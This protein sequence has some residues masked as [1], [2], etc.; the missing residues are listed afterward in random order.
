M[1]DVRGEARNCGR[2]RRPAPGALVFAL[3][4]ACLGYAFNR[5]EAWVNRTESA[6][7][8]AIATVFWVG[9]LASAE[10]RYISNVQNAW[11]RDWQQHFGGVDHPEDRCGY[12][13]CAFNPRENSFYVAL[14]FD[15]MTEEGRKKAGTSFIPW[16]VPRTKRSVL[17][18]RWIAIHANGRT[19]YGQW[20]DVG[21]FETD[22]AAYVF[23]ANPAPK[24]RIGES[25]G[26]DLSPAL[27]DCLRTRSVSRVRWRHVEYHEVPEGPWKAVI[28]TRP[29]P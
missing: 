27:R 4:A 2:A 11:D 10:N 21:P 5:A 14:P 18:N 13:P 17:K 28:T 3:S 19:C 29:G 23:G 1:G 9:E 24:N 8:S 15:E 20:E 26:I 16:N 7:K 6:W 25:A 22:D 12:R